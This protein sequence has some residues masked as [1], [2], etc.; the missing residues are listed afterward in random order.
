MMSN[1]IEQ[2]TY[3]NLT[4]RKYGHLKFNKTQN[5]WVL[6]GVEPHVSIKLKELFS[7]IGKTHTERFT[8]P[9]KP[10]VAADLL[11]F[12][13]R[14]PFVIDEDSQKHLIAQNDFYNNFQSHNESIVME[15]YIPK[16]TTGFKDS[17][18]MRNYQEVAIDLL[19]N[20]NNLLLCDDV[21]LGKTYTAIGA[22]LREGNLPCAVVVKRHLV[23]QWKR[24]IEK[25]SNLKVHVVQKSKY[26]KLPEADVFIYKYGS[27]L[28]WVDFFQTGYFKYVVY[29][30]IQELRTGS[31]SSKGGAAKALSK[32]AIRILGMTATPVYNYAED[33]FNIVNY[34]KPGFFPD[35]TQFCIEWCPG[36]SKFIKNKKAFNSYLREQYL[37][38]VRS[39]K[40]VGQDGEDPVRI[41]EPVDYD[42][43]AVKSTLALAKQLAMKIKT[44]SFVERGQASRELDMMARL[45]TGV[46]KAKYVA[47][48]VKLLLEKEK[49][50]VLVGWHRDC[51]AIWMKE[52]S[53]YKPVMYTG[54]ES[55]TQ[56]EKNKQQFIEGDSRVILISLRSGDGL[57]G[58]QFVC[59]TIVFGEFDWSHGV[60]YQCIGRLHREGQKNRV[61]AFFL[62]SEEGS[63][64]PM[65]QLIGSKKEHAY[66]IMGVDEEEN[67]GVEEQESRM[68]M[69][70]N[71]YLE[72]EH[73]MDNVLN[74]VEE[75]I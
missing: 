49:K 41:L 43:N 20:N 63:D 56:K 27:L 16:Q 70:A 65:L 46:S 21:G 71:Y 52:L 62:Y 28:G 1:I 4:N 57:D 13:Q 7:H 26:Y 59:S 37:L 29:D 74:K 22:M 55:D 19:M 11:W 54:S 73:N 5:Q 14:Y 15:T 48:F 61:T 18:G 58:L 8:F 32:N 47:E 69:L 6:S 33:I 75:I 66:G 12:S 25:I 67:I 35:W 53:K 31:K 17:Y 60:H 42:E 23:K 34:V 68:L 51:Y 50:V 72:K 24:V 30:E 44:G 38:L 64:P 39:K 10:D 45:N 3:R 9:G 36:K 40:D 2:G